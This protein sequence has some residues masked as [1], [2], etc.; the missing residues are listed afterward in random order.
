MEGS[1]SLRETHKQAE[2]LRN[3]IESSF[4]STSEIFQQNLLA[5]IQAYE[6]CLDIASRV[7]LFSPNESLEDIATADLQFL[8]LDYRLAELYMRVS[9]TDRKATILRS[10]Q[11]Y[12]GYLKRLDQYDILSKGDAQLLEEYEVA[13]NTFS[14]ASVKDPAARRDQ[15][16]KRFKEEKALKEK[17]AYMEKNPTVLEDDDNAYREVQLLN[18]SYCTHQAFQALESIAQELHILSLAPPTPP[19]DARQQEEDARERQGTSA[20][21]SERLDTNPL[22]AGMTG[23]LLDRSGKPLRPFTLFGSKREELRAGVFRPDHSLPT[24]TIDEYLEEERKRGGIIDGGGS[25]SGIKP[26]VDEDDMEASDR[27]TMK[28]REWD[29]YVE[30][31][32]RGSGNTINRG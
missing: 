16:I 30:A 27:A 15:K 28:A 29:E 26:E 21:F 31:N 5:A 14:T 12:S 17:L 6:Q 9:R 3:K 4:N 19:P 24:M 2:T 20:G 10:Q 7:A 23:P 8:L 18:L 25:Q 11:R 1:Q 32:P 22:S 13:P